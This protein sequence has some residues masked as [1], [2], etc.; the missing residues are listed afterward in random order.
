MRNL[1]NTIQGPDVV[2]GVDA[3]G[4]AAVET[5]NLVVDQGG[6]RKVV[7]EVGKV[8]PDVGVAVL[9]EAFV[10]EAIDLGNLAGLVVS[11]KDGYALGVSNLEGDE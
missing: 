8:L 10:I 3:R 2:Q 6:Q 7:E 4:Q 11:S 1:L 5:E 9:P